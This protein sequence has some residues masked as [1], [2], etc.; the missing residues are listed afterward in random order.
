MAQSLAAKHIDV[1]F[2]L[3]TAGQSFG[4]SSSNTVK[5]TGLRCNASVKK[6]GGA[7][8]NT[9]QLSVFG[10]TLNIMNQLTTLGKPAVDYGRNNIV[11]VEA[12]DDATPPAVVFTG[13]IDQAFA[14]G[15]DQ[16]NIP[17]VV[18][19]MTGLLDNMR[20]VP[21]TTRQGS[22]DVATLMSGFAA[23]MSMVF[24]NGGVS[25][26][27]LS[28]PYFSGTAMDQA[29]RCAQAAGINVA[30]D[31]GKLA[32][33]PS[34]G[35]RKAADVAV[36]PA[37]GMIGYP[38]WTANGLII[39]TLYNPNIAYG[40][41]VN[42]TSSLTTANGRWTVFKLQHDL[43]SET[44]GGKWESMFEASVFGHDVVS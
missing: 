20:P 1:T 26:L 6:A 16:P 12:Y 3:G 40:C 38:N 22:A 41:N 37:T 8:F 9:C 34:G 27:N 4:G 10:M 43:E 24:E 42:V 29:R 32:I 18:S 39:R 15:D 30:F 2:Q 7:G 35:S 17:F 5:L 28:N 21:P 44:P 23:T 25:G 14:A 19:A 11:T 33:W 31:D 36:S 13:I